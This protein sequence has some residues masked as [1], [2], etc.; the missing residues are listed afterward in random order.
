MAAVEASTAGCSQG[1]ES[2][3]QFNVEQAIQDFLA[4]PA[5]MSMRLPHMTTGQRR[6][7][8]QVASTYMELKVE[9]FGLGA[10]RHLHLFKKD[11]KDETSLGES[12]GATKATVEDN[13]DGSTTN[14][15]ESPGTSRGPSKDGSPSHAPGASPSSCRELPELPE[16]FRPEVRNTFLHIEEPVVH[17]RVVQ[18]MP[19]G[20]FRQQLWAE[21]SSASG[22]TSG[23]QPPVPPPAM[24]APT[25]AT[26]MGAALLVPGTQVV[27]QGLV[28]TP[29][30]NGLAGVIQFF[31]VDSGRYS[32]LLSS[33]GHPNGL[34]WAKIKAENLQL[35]CLPPAFGSFGVPHAC[36]SMPPYMPPTVAA[37]IE[38]AHLAGA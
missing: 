21:M 15:S 27:V 38:H 11:G 1:A 18:S 28:R 4:D 25:L 17:E 35:A 22:V 32:V 2:S 19:H 37:P 36:M 26:M 16:A 31:E 10:D 5:I 29:E 12:G 30:F 7:A 14:G 8:K 33:P 24:P 13:V 9:S 3:R 34:Q 20:M 23:G 6:H